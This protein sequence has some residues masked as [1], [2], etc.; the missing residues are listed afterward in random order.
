MDPDQT[1]TFWQAWSESKLFA[2]IISKQCS[3]H[4]MI[5]LITYLC[6]L[7]I[8]IKII[9]FENFF[10]EY[11]LCVKQIGS[12]SGDILSGLIWVQTVWKGNQ[13]MILG[14]RVETCMH[15]YLM[16]LEVCLVSGF[17]YFHTLYIAFLIQFQHKFSTVFPFPGRK[18]TISLLDGLWMTGKYFW[19]CFI[20]L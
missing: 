17:I 19:W 11:H 13:Q 16:G 9:V 10:Q 18:M 3:D 12:R 4:E 1:P 20:K 6:S 2:K 5:V 15:G 14:G 8:F 7:L